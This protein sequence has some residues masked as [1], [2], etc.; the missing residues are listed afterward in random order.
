[1]YKGDAGMV[2][3]SH[4]GGGIRP[5]NSVLSPGKEGLLMGEGATFCL[6]EVTSFSYSFMYWG[7]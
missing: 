7:P 2:P 6:G 3:P 4:S 1:M 5:R